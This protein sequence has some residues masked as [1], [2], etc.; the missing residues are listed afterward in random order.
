VHPI[1]AFIMWFS[2]GELGSPIKGIWL[3]GMAISQMLLALAFCDL[4]FK[5][6]RSRDHSR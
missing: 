6:R 2:T 4:G 5:V 3:V 1:L